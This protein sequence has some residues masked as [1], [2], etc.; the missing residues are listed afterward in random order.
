MVIVFRLSVA[1]HFLHV[2]HGFLPLGSRGRGICS[3][4]LLFC[5]LGTLHPGLSKSICDRRVMAS[6]ARVLS[7]SLF[8]SLGSKIFP[9]AWPSLASRGFVR[10]G[11]SGSDGKIDAEVLRSLGFVRARMFDAICIVE[12]YAPVR[13][14]Q[15]SFSAKH[16]SARLQPIKRGCD[17]FGGS[18]LQKKVGLEADLR[19]AQVQ[20]G[21]AIILLFLDHIPQ[22]SS[23]TGKGSEMRSPRPCPSKDLSGALVCPCFLYASRVRSF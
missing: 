16:F 14:E 20:G 11:L 18:C 7:C 3:G 13:Q 17:L 9:S 2:A 19:A 8:V 1:L 23:R 21:L 6:C 22:R 12:P 10:M 15:P 5:I 4:L